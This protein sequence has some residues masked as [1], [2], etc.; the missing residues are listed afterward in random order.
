MSYDCYCDYDSPEWTS[1]RNVKKSRKQHKCEEC[2]AIIPAGSTYEY[3]CGMWDGSINY[4]Y[5][6]NLCV[7]LREWATISV[8]CFCWA[9]GNLLAD[10]KDMVDNV[11]HEVPG[12]YFEYGR[13]MVKIRRVKMERRAGI[14][15]ACRALQAPV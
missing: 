1:H 14:E 4:F 15:P 10:V 6:C 13:R 7:E 2:R 5:T 9:H 8:P 11:R 12:L 3:V